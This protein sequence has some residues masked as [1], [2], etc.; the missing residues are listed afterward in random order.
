MPNGEFQSGLDLNWE[1][2]T[3]LETFLQDFISDISGDVE[4]EGLD[5]EDWYQDYGAYFSSYDPTQETM[6][7]E[8]FILGR[9]KF[10]NEIYTQLDKVNQAVGT[11]GFVSD[12][13]TI[14]TQQGV[15]RTAMLESL[16]RLLDYEMSLFDYRSS[17]QDETYRQIG[18]MAKADVFLVEEDE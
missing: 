1:V 14:E 18:E 6:A 7:S 10:L 8:K 2:E 4:G 16:E 11:G 9:T 13:N 3:D 12:H 17:W 15:E 5:F